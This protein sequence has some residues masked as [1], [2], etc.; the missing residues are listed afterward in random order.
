MKNFIFLLLPVLI[1]GC[2]RHIDRATAKSGADREAFVASVLAIGKAYLLSQPPTGGP[3]ANS[4]PSPTLEVTV[5]SL[6]AFGISASRRVSDAYLNSV[7]PEL[8]AM[9]RD[10]LI[11]GARLWQKGLRMSRTEGGV[12]GLDEQA[13]AAALDSE[14]VV[15]LDKH[16]EVNQMVVP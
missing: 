9:Y 14:W 4:A 2:T 16:V 11:A 7:H 8:S 5:D 12:A 13:A 3:A 15:W 10:K 1:L 6:T